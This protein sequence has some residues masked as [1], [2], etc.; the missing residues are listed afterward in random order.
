MTGKPR[1]PEVDQALGR[2]KADFEEGALR[3]LDL[4][5]G[6]REYSGDTGKIKASN[7]KI[8]VEVIV[9]PKESK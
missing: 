8:D 6:P 9:R 7:D 5:P 3:D 2:V 4:K 1:P